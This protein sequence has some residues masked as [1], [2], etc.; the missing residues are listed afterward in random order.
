VFFC[1]PNA[2]G[3]LLYEKRATTELRAQRNITTH[4]G[5]A[6]EYNALLDDS[7][8]EG[9]RCGKLKSDVTHF[10]DAKQNTLMPK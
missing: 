5:I 9:R 1:Y 3:F 8:A 10:G 7:R 2:F 4:F 6:L